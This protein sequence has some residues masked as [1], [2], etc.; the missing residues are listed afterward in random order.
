M[1]RPSVNFRKALLVRLDRI[2]DLVLTLPVDHHRVFAGAEV[3]WWIPKG[4]GFITSAATP[5]RQAIEVEKNFSWAT[6]N[7]LWRHLRRER[8]DIAVVFHAPW[9]IALLLW[10]ARVPV[11]VGPRSQWHSFLFFNKGVRQKRSQAVH[12]EMEYN[13][14]LVESALARESRTADVRHP[15]SLKPDPAS[16]TLANFS[17]KKD[18]YIVVHPGMGGSALNWPVERYA[19][20]IN[21]LSE[22]QTIV[23]TGTSADQPYLEPVRRAVGTN[24]KVV[25]LDGRLNGTELLAVLNG[26]RAVVAPSTGVLH[27]A[28]SCGVRT[29]GIFSPVPVQSVTR[30]GPKGPNAGSVFPSVNCPGH[31]SCLGPACALYNCMNRISVEEVC[32]RLV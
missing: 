31:F 4:L 21:R 16:P 28:A 19:E 6:M 13:F 32:Q 7:Q 24:T 8:Y 2:G 9:W 5:R 29:V 26:A 1:Q 11:R 14:K 18:G 12:H 20:L 3:Q 23:V 27:L 22:S 30:W 17:L 25:W 15:L 10:L